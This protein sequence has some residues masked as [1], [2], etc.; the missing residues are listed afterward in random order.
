MK[1]FITTDSNWEAK[2]EKVADALYDT[3]YVSFFEQQNYGT[4][5]NG[6]SIVLMCR[7]K[8]L[9]FKQRIRFIRNEKIIYMDLMFNIDE[10]LNISQGERE[11][12]VVNKIIEEVPKIVAKYKLADFNLTKFNKNL[13]KWMTKI[14]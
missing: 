4:S 10:F 6:I 5:L 7:D 3:G 8:N 9:N 12:I 1:L 11:K 13:N 14:L 2:I